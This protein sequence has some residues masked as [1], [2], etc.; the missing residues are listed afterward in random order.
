M[1]VKHWV[2]VGLGV[3]GALFVLHLW[4]SHGGVEGLKQGT[5]FG[6]LGGST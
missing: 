6:G 2:Y 3:V 5:G 4:M 1:K